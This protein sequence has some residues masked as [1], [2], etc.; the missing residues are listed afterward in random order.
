MTD[1][2]VKRFEVIVD[3]AFTPVIAAEDIAATE[4]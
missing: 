4:S 2:E 1:D 3:R